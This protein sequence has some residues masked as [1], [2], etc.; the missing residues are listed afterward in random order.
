LTQYGQYEVIRLFHA[1]FILAAAHIGQGKSVPFKKTAVQQS[2]ICQPNTSPYHPNQ[3]LVSPKQ[4]K[5]AG[6]GRGLHKE[7]ATMQ[8]RPLSSPQ[9]SLPLRGVSPTPKR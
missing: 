4:R 8:T 7:G 2:A 9:H 5:P 1:K 6:K 3:A